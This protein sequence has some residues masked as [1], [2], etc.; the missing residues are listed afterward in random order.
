MLPIF[1]YV[2]HLNSNLFAQLLIS[3]VSSPPN[4]TR[5]SSSIRQREG[6]YHSWKVQLILKSNWTGQYFFMLFLKSYVLSLFI[7]ISKVLQLPSLITK[8]NYWLIDR[9]WLT[10]KLKIQ[11]CSGVNSIK[12]IGHIWNLFDNILAKSNQNGFL[13]LS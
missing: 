11:E 13:H 5:T 8:I 4:I 12:K 1:E 7:L 2:L 9:I 3:T 6:K 10:L